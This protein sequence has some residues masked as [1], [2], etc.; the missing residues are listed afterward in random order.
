MDTEDITMQRA[1][2]PPLIRIV[3]VNM[4][5]NELHIYYI[6]ITSIY[7]TRSNYI[8]RSYVVIYTHGGREE[9]RV[10]VGFRV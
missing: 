9:G 10:C 7:I 1:L 4:T 6:N 5:T 3:K 2:R 8:Y